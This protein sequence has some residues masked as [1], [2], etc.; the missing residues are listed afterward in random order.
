[1]RSNGCGDLRTEQ[2]N[3]S[4]QLCGWVDRRRNHGGLIFID[5]RDCS[6]TVQIVA[7]PDLGAA[8]FTAVEH[9]RSETVLQVSGIV[10]ER[11]HKSINKKL[12]TGYVEVLA[13]DITVLNAVRVNLPLSVSIHDEENNREELRLRYRYLDL[14]RKRMNDNLRLRAQTIQVARRFLED[15]GFIEVETPMLTRSTPEGA[16]DYLVPSRVCGGDWFALPQSPQ[17]FKQLLMVG[18]IEQYYQVARCFR[19]EDLRADRQPE[20]TQLD[21]EMSFL[22]QDQI[23]DLNERL[24]CTLWKAVKS[25]ELPRPFPRITWQDAMERYGTDRPDTR[26]GMELINVSDIVENTGFQVFSGAVRAGGVVKCIAIPDGNS[27]L[28]NVRIKPG[29]DV[30]TQAEAA[31]ANG[32]AFIRVQDGGEINAISAIK[33]NLS[34]E[35]KQELLN[36]ADAKSGTLLL[37]GAGDTVMVNRALDRVRQYLARELGMVRSDRNNDRWN[38]LWVVDFPMFIFNSDEN[39][40]EAV[41]HPFCAPNTEDLG[42]IPERWS[43]TL[44]NARAQ[45]YDLVLNGLE[46]GGG[47]L[48]IHDANLQYQVLQTIGLSQEAAQEQFG[49]LMDALKMGAPPHGGLALGLDRVVMVL[50]GEESIRDIIAFPKTQQARCLMTGAPGAVVERQLNELHVASTLYRFEHT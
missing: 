25:I 33:N 3:N 41:H 9:L 38:F 27:T 14:R 26:F 16:R 11:P 21:M 6:G 5:L 37:F 13:T 39:R 28:S 30:F 46:L 8:A 44:P 43:K 18:G 7:N 4:V 17:L 32:L 22:D 45:A 31:G 20:F 2:V 42:S 34:S 10:Q 15:E 35:Q 19:D 12:A 49:F 40:L 47:S 29:G 50:A 1:M 48:R 24:I 36:R 23:L